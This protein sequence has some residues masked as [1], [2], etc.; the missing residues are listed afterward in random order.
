MKE[1]KAIIQP[2]KLT[3]IINALKAISSLP[4]VTVSEV[5]GFGRVKAQ[6]HRRERLLEYFS[7][8]THIFFQ[9]AF[10]FVDNL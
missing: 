10:W 4:G 8:P 3:D 2:F 9:G 7:I 1:I 6:C 5:K